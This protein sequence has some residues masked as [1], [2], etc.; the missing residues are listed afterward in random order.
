MAIDFGDGVQRP[1]PIDWA[2]GSMDYPQVSGSSSWW[3]NIFNPTFAE[4]KYNSAQA[5]IDRQ[6]AASE[7][8][9]NRDWQE[10][11][12]STAYRRAAEDLRKAGFNPYVA[13]FGNQASTPSGSALASSGARASTRKGLFED[14]IGSALSLAGTAMR[15]M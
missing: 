3:T 10:R 15:M 7:A 11:M 8:Q 13:A 9:K 1:T 12:S 5:M 4:Q 6:F 14:L 2:T